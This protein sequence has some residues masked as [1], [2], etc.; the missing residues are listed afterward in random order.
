VSARYYDAGSGPHDGEAR[1]DGLRNCGCQHD[2]QRWLSL[3]PAA[4]AEHDALHA[5]AAADRNSTAEVLP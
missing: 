2:G 1:E 5:A 4:R 3:C